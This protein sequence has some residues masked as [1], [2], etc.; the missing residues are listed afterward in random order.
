MTLKVWPV[1]HYE[2]LISQ[3][4]VRVRDKTV[5]LADTP[6]GRDIDAVG[7]EECGRPFPGQVYHK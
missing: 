4:V 3:G 6:T 1:F 7:P 2:D 5:R